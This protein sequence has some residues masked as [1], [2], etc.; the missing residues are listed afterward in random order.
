MTGVHTRNRIVQTN[1]S[2]GSYKTFVGTTLINDAPVQV[3]DNFIQRTT[4][5]GNP[6]GRTNRFHA[7]IVKAYGYDPTGSQDIGGPFQTWKVTSVAYPRRMFQLRGGN[8]LSTNYKYDGYASAWDSTPVFTSSDFPIPS[9]AAVLNSLGTTAIARC[10]PTNPLAGMGQFLGELHDLPKIPALRAWKNRARNLRNGAK[11]INFDKLSREAAGEYLNQVFGWMPFVGD[12]QKFAKTAKN[13]GPLMEKFA[14][15]SNHLI[16]RRYYFPDVTTT[17]VQVISSNTYPDPALNVSLWTGG[18]V[19]TKTTV[20]TTK[21]WFAGAFTYYLPPID[22]KDNGFVQTINKWKNAESQANRLFGLRLNPD[23]L[24]KLAP[25]S[26]AVDWATNAGDVVHN[27]SS[28]ASDGLVLNYGY[29][30]EHKVTKVTY[31]L[32]GVAC[33]A[34][35]QDFFQELTYEV[36]TRQRATPYG[37]G[38]NPASFTAKQWSIIAALGISKSPLSLNF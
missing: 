22:R 18:G 17:A 3:Y 28:F 38:V 12:L 21:Q 34:G 11:R 19:L 7:K 36:K 24:W 30:M 20:T 9:S 14:S 29:I 8:P 15:G 32:V 37:F 26:W 2:L 16:H 13:A 35:K 10:I 1:S 33:S 6:F 23:L 25:W 27:W 31:S 4:S 5:Q